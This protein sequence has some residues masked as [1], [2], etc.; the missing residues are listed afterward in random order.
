VPAILVYPHLITSK[1][2]LFFV[3]R[4]TLALFSLWFVFGNGK[5]KEKYYTY[6]KINL[7]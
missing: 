2:A 4:F 5:N 3:I 1:A 6:L 7:K